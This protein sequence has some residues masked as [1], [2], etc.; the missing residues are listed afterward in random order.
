MHLSYV[1]SWATYLAIFWGYRALARNVRDLQVPGTG[2]CF[3]AVNSKDSHKDTGIQS[4]HL[5]T[6]M[7]IWLVGLSVDHLLD[8]CVLA[9]FKE[10]S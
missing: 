6:L 1:S 2:V 10:R 7:V 9:P 5:Q 3:L 4:C 8:I